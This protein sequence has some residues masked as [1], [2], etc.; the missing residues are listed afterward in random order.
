MIKRMLSRFRRQSK[1]TRQHSV[2]PVWQ[3]GFFAC[4]LIGFVAAAIWLSY[5]ASQQIGFNVGIWGFVGLGCALI[6]GLLW[7]FS[8]IWSAV[9][10]LFAFS[11]E[12]YVH[13]EYLL[14]QADFQRQKEI[15]TAE[16]T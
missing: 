13:S 11:C 3:R 6:S 14:Q 2:V 12:V 4:A 7:H 15:V 1:V 9:F 5:Q 16:K 8:R 10:V